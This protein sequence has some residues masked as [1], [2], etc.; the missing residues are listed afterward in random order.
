VNKITI[1]TLWDF[2]KEDQ[3]VIVQ[4]GG[5]AGEYRITKV[6]SETKFFYEPC[7][8]FGEGTYGEA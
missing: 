6:F 4:E 7:P 2:T 8:G 1:G 3:M 5:E